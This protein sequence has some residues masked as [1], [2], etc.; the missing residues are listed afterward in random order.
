MMDTVVVGYPVHAVKAYSEW[1]NPYGARF[2]TWRA[3]CGASDTDSG[4]GRT[5]PFRRAGSA[6]RAEL[7]PA[8]FPGRDHNAASVHR[9]HR[10]D[11]RDAV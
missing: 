5:G 2:T 9:P 3:T 8:C 11:D 4:H 1:T 10:V 6:R 7:C